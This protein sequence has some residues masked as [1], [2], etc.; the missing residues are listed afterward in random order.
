MGQI[1]Y[2]WTVFH[3]YVSLLEGTPRMSKSC[4]H[5]MEHCCSLPTQTKISF[6]AFPRPRPGTNI[7]F[8]EFNR[9]QRQMEDHQSTLQMVWSWEFPGIHE[10]FCSN[11]EKDR[12][13]CPGCY[14]WRVPCM[15]QVSML[16]YFCW[17]MCIHTYIILY[18]NNVIHVYY[19][20]RFIASSNWVVWAKNCE[21]S[22]SELVGELHD[23]WMIRKWMNMWRGLFEGITNTTN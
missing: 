21:D 1:I 10:S 14:R 5:T 3:S 7:S 19:M 22:T 12:N 15:F 8:E 4:R 11:S 18:N 17:C 16:L 6:L 20:D 23:D 13:A 2:N 9:I